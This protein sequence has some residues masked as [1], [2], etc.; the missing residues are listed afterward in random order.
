MCIYIYIYILFISIDCPSSSSS[1]WK[2]SSLA[3]A[4]VAHDLLP[5]IIPNVIPKLP[6]SIVC[7][8]HFY[9]GADD[10]LLGLHC[11]FGHGNRILFGHGPGCSLCVQATDI[12][13]HCFKPNTHLLDT[14]WREALLIA[15]ALV[16]ETFPMMMRCMKFFK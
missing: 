15:W 7:H 8:C 1:C 3:V 12:L 2:K 10:F 9:H 4:Q 13:P 14:T 11:C 5:T 6:V 16:G